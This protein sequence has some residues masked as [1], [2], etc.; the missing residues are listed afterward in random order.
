MKGM[1]VLFNAEAFTVMFTRW[2]S[3]FGLRPT[4]VGDDK[5]ASVGV[6]PIDEDLV[7]PRE[8]GVKRVI[9]EDEEF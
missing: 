7:A 8:P 6:L 2:G 9:V 1:I 5:L 3:Y 4:W